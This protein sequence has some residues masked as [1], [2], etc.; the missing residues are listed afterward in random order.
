[1]E[2]HTG[3]LIVIPTY[4]EAENLEAMIREIGELSLVFDVLIVDDHS[5]DGTGE[6]ADR[7]AQARPNVHVMHRAGKLGLGTAYIAGFRWALARDYAYVMEMDCD[8]SHHPRYLPTFM[9]QI[10]DADLVIGSRY[11]PGGDTP[12]WGLYRRL[13]STGGNLFAR[14]LLGLSTH[15]CTGGYRCYRRAIVEQVPW[16]EIGLQGYGFQIGAVYHIERMGGR[17]AEFPIVFDDRQLGN[18]K[19]SK[20]IVIEAMKFVVRLALRG[21]RLNARRSTLQR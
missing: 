1:M 5:P 11:V 18:S 20:D 7:L 4:N 9:E 13:M 15:D 10:A 21:G 6:I 12:D 3:A 2:Q 17:I 14:T 8:F 16:D 19:M